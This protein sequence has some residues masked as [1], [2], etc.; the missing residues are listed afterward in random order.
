MTLDIRP[1]MLPTQVFWGLTSGNI[2]LFPNFIPNP[3]AA[4]SHIQTDRKSDNVIEN[5]IAGIFRNTERDPSIN[6]S[7]TKEKT[8]L[9]IFNRGVC[10]FLNNSPN[11]AE[12][13][14]PITK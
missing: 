5:P 9:L 3:K 2:F 4:V 10:F 1:A 7:Q 6:P 14:I 13:V 12:K 8:T 11:M